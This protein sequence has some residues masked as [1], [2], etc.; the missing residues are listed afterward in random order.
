MRTT[1]L[2][3]CRN[4]TSSSS[5][6]SPS[7]P[8]PI[9]LLL[10][11]EARCTRRRVDLRAL[12]A[13]SLSSGALRHRFAASRLLDAL[14]RQC[15]AAPAAYTAA[16]F[17]SL[18]QPDAYTWNAFI[19]AQSRRRSPPAASL[20]LYF[21]MRTAVAAPPTGYTFALLAKACAAGPP[22]AAVAEG[23][24][25]HGQMMKC[26][27]ELAAVVRN[28]LMAMYCG[29]GL[30]Q[31]ARKL[32]DES[33]SP[34][35]IPWNTMISAYGKNGELREAWSLLERMPHRNL[36]S[37]SAMIDGCVRCGEHSQ[38]LTLFKNM[39]VNGGG[40]LPDAVAVV[41]ALT[42]CT[43][44]GD[45][46][47]GRWLHLLA[48]R[49]RLSPA[50][51]PQ[52]A[53]ALGD[54]YCK[55]GSLEAALQVFAAVP[56]PDVVLC[57]VMI[58]G[59]A[60]HG[61][62]PAALE[63]FRRMIAAG[64]PPPDG[65]TFVAVLRACAHSGLVREGREAFAAMAELG[66]ERHREHYGCLADLLARAGMVEEAEKVVSSMPME[67]EAAQWGAVAAGCRSHWSTAVGERVG[68]RMISLE[69][70][71]PGRYVQ[72]ANAYA[73]AGRWEEAAAARAAMEGW[74]LGR[75]WGGASWSWSP[76]VVEVVEVAEEEM[77]GWLSPAT[78]TATATPS[79][80]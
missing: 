26:G 42:A 16:V 70:K 37:W 27:V 76:V 31:D 5:S 30:L 59:L 79:G 3:K 80:R 52:L 18:H 36:I 25:L 71:D 24:L 60:L 62:G 69:P 51:N 49:R 66:V 12:H 34:D 28:S 13:L 8:H 50:E 55:C 63:L 68:R 44:L 4:F 74:E 17:D 77:G 1:A 53:A 64:A 78:A 75:R 33:P 45:L 43:H 40:L 32:F 41:S 48:L 15:A 73:A 35:P 10:E 22:P 61:R 11:E 23:K 7:S 19:A 6:S 14:L 20:Q 46:H 65:S 72:M 54:M 58:S 56:F 47:Y 39:Q 29:M 2:Q 38:A 21:R 67:P 9:L 57:N